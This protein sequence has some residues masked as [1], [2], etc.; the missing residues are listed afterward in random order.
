MSPSSVF[1]RLRHTPLGV[2]CRRTEGQQLAD[3]VDNLVLFHPE[4]DV[5]ERPA[6][7]DDLVTE[8]VGEHP[9]ALQQVV[10]RALRVTSPVGH[11]PE[12]AASLERRATEPRSGQQPERPIRS[13][14]RIHERREQAEA[15]GED[16]SERTGEQ[17]P[18][19]QVERLTAVSVERL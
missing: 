19:D 2:S 8:S 6:H 11:S 12:R 3:P 1:P 10:R 15:L 7:A 16:R 14:Q 17:V 4:I 9:V 5:H 13:R 18:D